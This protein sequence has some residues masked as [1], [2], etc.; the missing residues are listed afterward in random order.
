MDEHLWYSKNWRSRSQPQPVLLS[1]NHHF[2]QLFPLL[3]LLL[4]YDM[5]LH[6]LAPH[7]YLF[8][9]VPIF[10]LLGKIYRTSST[11][12]RGYNTLHSCT[13]MHLVM[14][15]FILQLPTNNWRAW[16]E[17]KDCVYTV[18]KN[19]VFCRVKVTWTWN[20]RAVNTWNKHRMAKRDTAESPCE[21][22]RALERLQGREGKVNRI[23]YFICNVV[24]QE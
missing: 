4:R 21:C 17:T 23:F 10:Y 1:R 22:I 19:P 11:S 12:L 5:S 24:L 18:H 3:V 7:F 9:V 13:Q 14:F 6:L 15:R 2:R 20:Q 8:V 16:E